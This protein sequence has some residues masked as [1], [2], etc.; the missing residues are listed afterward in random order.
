MARKGITFDQV[1]NAAAA[2]KARGSEPTIAAVRMELGDEGS[3]T[4]ISQHL[5]RWRTE[6]ADKVDGRSLP[7]EIENVMM[8]ALMKVWNVAVRA[9][10]DDLNSIKQ[11]FAD[12]KKKLI[13]ECDESKTE[14]QK[15]ETKLEEQG[16]IIEGYS[17]RHNDYMKASVKQNGELDATRELYKQLL[18]SIKPP[19][20]SALVE[21]KAAD[22]KP[23]HQPKKVAA[24]GNKSAGKR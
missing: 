10:A 24:P 17:N 20:A 12:E 19:A 9:A 23:A 16:K 21:H 6:A 5:A 13:A 22:T 4:T 1:A 18:A 14:I 8:E 3:F 11:D 7:T 2:I 15:L